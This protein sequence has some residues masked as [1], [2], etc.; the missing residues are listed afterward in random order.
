MTLYEL[1][2]DGSIFK[3]NNQ[4]FLTGIRNKLLVQSCLWSLYHSL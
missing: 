2:N 4:A 1:F 3:L